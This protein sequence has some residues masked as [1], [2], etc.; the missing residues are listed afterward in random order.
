MGSQSKRAVF[1]DGLVATLSAFVVTNIALFGIVHI[2]SAAIFVFATFATFAIALWA[3]FALLRKRRRR[4]PSREK[5][6]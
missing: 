2:H 6:P 4:V 3:T 5:H 1:V